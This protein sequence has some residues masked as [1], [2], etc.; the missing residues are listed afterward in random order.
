MHPTFFSRAILIVF[1]L[2][3]TVRAADPFPLPTP[4]SSYDVGTLHIDQFGA[5]PHPLILI[6]GL[7]GGPWVYSDLIPR[8]SSA[9][10]LYL[11]TLPGFDG[12]P[13]IP[14]KS[15]F[16]T[17]SQNFW[18]LLSDHHIDHPALIGH[19]LGG[20]LSFSLAEEHPE[21]LS[22]VIA[23]DGLPIFPMLAFST[24]DQRQTMAS[25]MAST[26]SSLSKSE[27]LANQ[28]SF[29]STMGTSK[30][31]LVGPAAELQSRSDPKAIAAWIEEDLTT[32][33]RPNLNK[34]TIPL[35][36]LM[37][38]DPADH[39]PYTQPQ[40]LLFYQALLAGTPHATV[41][42][43]TPSRHFIMLDQPDLFYQSITHFLSQVASSQ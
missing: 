37:P 27:L 28:K 5:G 7:A 3:G 26:F 29:L 41:L 40:T 38:Y 15:L 1:T 35:L 13:F 39:S 23:I 8:L 12:Q 30:P 14:E 11:L 19:S 33:L 2:I 31:E 20:T 9:H 25:Q 43:I 34:I 4:T 42:P 6:P 18:T 22:S 24:P 17:F 10:T 36:E 32:D 21:R 16:N